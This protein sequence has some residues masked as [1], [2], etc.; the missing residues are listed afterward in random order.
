MLGSPGGVGAGLAL[1]GPALDKDGESNLI[2]MIEGLNACQHCCSVLMWFCFLTVTPHSSVVAAGSRSAGAGKG[3]ANVCQPMCC[4]SDSFFFALS[5]IKGIVH[6]KIWICWKCTHPLAIQELDEF[7]IHQIWRNVRLHSLAPQ[8]IL[9][10]EWVPSE[11][12]SK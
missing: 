1:G 9:F 2:C 10:R 8:W 6:P 11:W 7:V 5:E 12:E 4:R 3:I